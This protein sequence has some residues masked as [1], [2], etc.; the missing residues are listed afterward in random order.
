M[1]YLWLFTLY[2]TSNYHVAYDSELIRTIWPVVGYLADSKHVEILLFVVLNSL[3]F[4]WAQ[5]TWLP[6][7]GWLFG[8]KKKKKKKDIEIWT[9]QAIDP[10][11]KK[12]IISQNY[13]F[14]FFFFPY[15]KLGKRD[16]NPCLSNK[17]TTQHAWITRINYYYYYYFKFRNTSF[18]HLI[19]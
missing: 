15:K 4:Y 10:M 14:F 9:T 12:K 2:Y 17:K 11:A 5:S 13:W 6:I 7:W 3:N 19:K 16:S 1:K 18:S 8:G